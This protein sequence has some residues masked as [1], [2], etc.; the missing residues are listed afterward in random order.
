M[1][2]APLPYDIRRIVFRT[3]CELGAIVDSIHDVIE[4]VLVESGMC[5]ART[6]RADSFKAVWLLEEGTVQFR[7]A[8][9]TLLRVVNLYEE[10]TPVR[11]AA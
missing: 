1:T 6:Y 5:I 2:I 11:M 9:G 3:L 4:T 8:D 7:D 10:M